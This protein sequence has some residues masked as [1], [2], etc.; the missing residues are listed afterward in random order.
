MKL[1]VEKDVL[2]IISCEPHIRAKT[3]DIYEIEFDF[4]K[5]WDDFS[6]KIVYVYGADVYE[7][8]IV[9]NKTIV[10]SL[11]AGKCYA[12][13]VV[14]IKIEN[15]K[16]VKRKATNMFPYEI[17]VS[18]AEFKTNSE[19]TE[20]EANTYE[21]YLQEITE[22]SIEIKESEK[23][24]ENLKTQIDET[25][26]S[27]KQIQQ[28]I[29]NIVDDFINN[30]EEKLKEYNKNAEEKIVDYNTNASTKK[31]EIIDMVNE[32][33][34]IKDEVYDIATSMN[35]AQ[36]YVDKSMKIHI[37]SESE[38][39]NN[40]FYVEKGKIGVRRYVN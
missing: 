7:G 14:G 5:D 20:E 27:N 33:T 22:K 16:I 39:A 40:K 15:N 8:A 38:M 13:G 32:V 21:K 37:I 18:S 11:P 19:I 28:N 1:K 9:N 23:V 4:S 24:I 36:F 34:S 6:K 2:G 10:P 17:T 31:E 25:Y 29:E 12:I 35:F 26:S 30:S 3:I